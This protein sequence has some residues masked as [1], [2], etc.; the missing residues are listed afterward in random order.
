MNWVK[1]PSSSFKSGIARQK[2]LHLYPLLF[3]SI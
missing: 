3:Q 1:T 2:H